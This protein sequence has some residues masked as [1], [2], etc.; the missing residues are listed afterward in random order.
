M[1]KCWLAVIVTFL[2]FMAVAHY[3][4]SLGACSSTNYYDYGDTGPDGGIVFYLEGACSGMEAQPYD[5]GANSA[6]AYI[7]MW[8]DWD[9]AIT[10][11]AAYNDTT[12]TKALSCPTTANPTTSYCWH[13]PSRTELSYLYE[14]RYVVGG[15][16]NI[17]YWSST[18][19]NA[20]TGIIK[21]PS[22]NYAWIQY[23]TYGYQKVYNKY[24]YL[25]VR[26][27]RAF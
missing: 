8:E 19:P 27:V 15:F 18:E 21:E 14:Q 20:F 6:N 22:G 4:S 3:D 12:I 23:F 9:D 5:V 1:T 17:Y 7:G 16:A 10:A 26:A 11:S 13:L 25:P 24:Y 2:P